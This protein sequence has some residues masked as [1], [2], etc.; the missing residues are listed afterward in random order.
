MENGRP[1][2]LATNRQPCISSL[3]QGSQYSQI[4]EEHGEKL[5]LRVI[6]K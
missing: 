3:D 2:V 6:K 5:K 1:A 4:A